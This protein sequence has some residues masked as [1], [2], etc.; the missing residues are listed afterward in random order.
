MAKIEAR[1]MR[2]LSPHLM[3]FRPYVNMMMSILHRI[4]GTANYFGTL[5]LAALAHGCGVGARTAS[6]RRTG[7]RLRRSGC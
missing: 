7:S 6:W 3:I 5:L 2:P 4:T 1:P